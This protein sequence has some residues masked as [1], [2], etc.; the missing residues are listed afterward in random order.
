MKTEVEPITPASGL[1]PTVK[2]WACCERAVG[3]PCAVAS[4]VLIRE[5]GARIGA[6]PWG[7]ERFH[8]PRRGGELGAWSPDSP[9]PDC[10]TPPGGLHHRGCQLAGCGACGGRLLACGCTA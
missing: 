7:S 5:G 4:L 10:A 8:R 1:G 9:C 6:V 3:E 2:V